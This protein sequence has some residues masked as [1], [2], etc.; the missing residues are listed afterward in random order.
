MK[1]RRI[2]VALAV[3]VLLVA[4]LFWIARTA[5]FNAWI[6]VNVY[7]VRTEGQLQ[8]GDLAPDLSLVSVEGTG[9]HRLSDFYRTRPTILVFG[10]YT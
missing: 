7:D 8:V 3:V 10:S 1:R 5:V 4:G 6:R 2:V 9:E